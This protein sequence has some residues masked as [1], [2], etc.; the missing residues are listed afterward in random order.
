MFLYRVRLLSLVGFTVWVDVSWL[1]FAVL[2]AWSLA[3]GIFPL[4]TPGLPVATYWWMAVVGTIGLFFSIV[5]HELAHSL[6]AR[7]FAMPIS[8]ITLFIFGGVAELHSEPTSPRSEFLMA[9]A[10][11][12]ASLVLGTAFLAIVA[13]GAGLPQ[14]LAGVLWYLG[15]I[16]C[17][18]AIFNLVPAFPLDG[19]RMLRAALWAWKDDLRWATNIAANAGAVFGILLIAWGVFQ[20]VTGNV[21]GGMWLFL[22]GMFL[23]GAAGAARQQM[24]ARETFAGRPV[25]RFMKRQPITVAPDLPLRQLIE[26][27]FYRYHHKAFPVEQNGK[28]LGC[29]TAD[30]LRQVPPEEWQSR[31]VRDVMTPCPPDSIVSPSTDAFDALMQM[32][33]TGNGWLL[34]I[35]ENRLC[36]IL[37]L[38]DMLQIL[39]LKLEFGDAEPQQRPACPAAERANR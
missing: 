30:R 14:P 37:S 10:G 20:L 33:R 5:F 9:V 32:Q 35:D 24:I 26:D 21:A 29:V 36:G 19:G 27:Y 17:V 38:S 31:T 18:L 34:V 7:S 1:I 25:A 3:T 13:F 12:V 23:H 8:G 16:N 15:Y 11:P 39:S 2:L 28:L 6:V 22:I 4:I